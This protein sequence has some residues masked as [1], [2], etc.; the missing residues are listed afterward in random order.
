MKIAI[1]GYGV[2]GRALAEYFMKKGYDITVCDAHE[3]P[4]PPNIG[5]RIK[6]RFGPQYLQNLGEFDMIFRSPG[7]PYLSPE[8]DPVR[9]KLTSLTRYFFD[10]CPCPI[11]GITGTKGKGTTSTLLY[12]MAKMAFVPKGRNVFLGGNIGRPLLVFLPELTERDIVILELSSFQLQDLH[13][14]PHIAVVLGITPDHLDHHQNMN[15][16]VAAKSNIVNFQN[17]NDIAVLDMDNEKSTQF[18][19]MTP[20]QKFSVSMKD[21]PRPSRPEAK[22]QRTPQQAAET[23]IKAGSFVLRDNKE[24]MIFGQKGE[25]KLLG[26][27]NVKNILTAA[28]AAHALGVPVEAIT[29]VAREFSGL[30]HRLEFVGEMNGAKFYNDSASTNPDTAIAALRCFNN[31]VILILGGSDKNVDFTP[32]AKEISWRHNIRTVILMGETQKN[33]EHVIE[34]AAEYEQ[35]KIQSNGHEIHRREVPLELILSENYQEA[36]M[37]ARLLAQPGDTVLLSPACASFDMFDNY[38]QRGDIFRNFVTDIGQ[39]GL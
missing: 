37:V 35:K 20:A 18:A 17:I 33:L 2:E 27:H 7:V 9:K 11:V 4:K 1:I 38:Q 5:S 25:T 32:L 30:P 19:Q 14:S 24:T 39:M 34:T 16:Y 6:F 23:F 8:F 22:L 3:K 29:K 15:E 12:E 28:T 13:K 21:A 31:P 26:E 36:F 10:H